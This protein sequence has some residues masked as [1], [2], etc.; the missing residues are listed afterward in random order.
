VLELV[1]SF[2]IL[3]ADVNFQVADHKG[4]PL[5]GEFL[6]YVCVYHCFCAS[7]FVV[8]PVFCSLF[9]IFLS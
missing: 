1:V 4:T 9:A 6:V 5:H 2:I 8:V 3:G 7:L